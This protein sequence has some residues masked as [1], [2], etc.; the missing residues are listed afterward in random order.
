MRARQDRQPDHIDV[1]LE[2][3]RGDHLGR[4][5]E[6]RVDDL[7][8]L[9]AQSPGEHLGAPVMAVEAGLRDEHLERSLGHG[10]IVAHDRAADTAGV[11][12]SPDRE[13]FDRAQRRNRRSARLRAI[14]AGLAAAAMGIPLGVYLSPVLLALAIIVT[15]LVNFLVPTADVGGAVWTLLDRLIDGDPGTVQAI[16]WILVIWV[17]P[18]VVLLVV[19]YLLV[20]W[21]LRRIGG[22]GIALALGARPPRPADPEETQLANVATELA[23]A[24]GIEPPRVL[25]YDNGPANAFVFGRDPDHA[26]VVVGRGLL[27]ELDREETQGVVARVI[28]S[29]VGGDL[30]LA[31][32]IAAVYVTYGLMI[33]TLSAVVSP[34]ARA[35]LRAAVGPL[36]GRGHDPA[37]AA[38]GVAALLGAVGRRRDARYDRRRLSHPG[39]DGWPHRRRRVA[40][41][42][43]PERTA[44]D[45]RLALARLPGRRDGGR[46]DARCRR[47]R[48]R[49]DRRLGGD[50]RSVPGTAW[51]ELLLVVGGSSGGSPAAALP[52]LSDSGLATSL[53]PPLTK[54]L[55][56]LR[57]MGASSVP[58]SAPSLR[59]RTRGRSRLPIALLLIV[60][61]PLIALLAV[62]L[63]VAVVLIVYLVAFAA[64]VVLAIVAG[65]LHEL[66][67]SLAGR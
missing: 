24:A 12:A 11:R 51:L 8:A 35:R 16:A 40:H 33:T 37:H 39:H 6:T 1:L 32:D 21:R 15:D 41:Q 67:R 62:L 28:G 23:I 49:L 59:E 43:V 54:R 53:A 9:V 14:P 29:A 22:E 10:P 60:I 42:P 46:A 45:V 3:G 55:G 26:T 18:G 64:F 7:E 19:A 27:D 66:L 50:G 5:A 20:A 34:T 36:V 38:T 52:R 48:S 44:A 30:G 13:E 56:R 58:P 4:L 2:R 17:V 47:P 25:L 57:A 61:I 65:P 63:A 31:V